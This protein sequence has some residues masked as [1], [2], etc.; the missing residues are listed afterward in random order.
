MGFFL[1][2][3][4]FT[5]GDDALTFDCSDQ[6]SLASWT[7]GVSSFAL[8]SSQEQLGMGSIK[9][10]ID[11]QTTASSITLSP[12]V[13][14]GGTQL[15]FDPYEGEVSATMEITVLAWADP[16]A[17]TTNP[18]TTPSSVLLDVAKGI[19]P[20]GTVSTQDFA[21]NGIPRVNAGVIAGFDLSFTPETTLSSFYGLGTAVGSAVS[22][23]STT[24]QA[25][26]LV[27]N[28][29]VS[30]DN[31]NWAGVGNEFSWN[32]SADAGLIGLTTTAPNIYVGHSSTHM[33]GNT[34]LTLTPTLPSSWQDATLTQAA[35]FL[36][37]YYLQ[38]RITGE[39]S[40]DDPLFY[41]MNV[42][43]T[44]VTLGDDGGFS[45]TSTTTLT[46]DNNGSNE[47]ASSYAA[48]YLYILLAGPSI[49]SVSPSSGPVAGGGTVTISGVN[50]QDIE[51]VKFG[52]IQVEAG[53]ITTTE[54]GDLT[55]SA[56][57]AESA[58]TVDIRVLTSAG[59]SQVVSADQYT[60]TS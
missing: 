42:G 54:S 21:L 31:D 32:N 7:Y 57:A 6:G 59:I 18:A 26:P 29:L 56:P 33:S 23:Y 3:Q 58:G 53:D 46:G 37:A 39:S 52:D 49:E 4:S 47:G 51:M 25:Y 55:M 20:T 16:T 34:S 11:A 41:N 8:S 9:L 45:F 24:N 38:L 17:D 5:T 12:T 10:S 22:P 44:D 50:L 48:N 27:T 43:A 40:W 19:T 28:Q 14:Y 60:Y 35:V 30:A 36:H 15:P 13:W 1:Q 2:T